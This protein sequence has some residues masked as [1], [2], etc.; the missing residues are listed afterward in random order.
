MNSITTLQDLET[1]AR[2]LRNDRSEDA[3]IKVQINATKDDILR[4]SNDPLLPNEIDSISSHHVEVMGVL[5]E[6]VKSKKHKRI[7]D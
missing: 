2:G 7:K 4:L 3:V 5:F 6:L 1:I